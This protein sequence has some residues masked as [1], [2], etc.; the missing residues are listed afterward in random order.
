MLVTICWLLL[1]AVAAVN[2]TPITSLRPIYY[3]MLFTL[4]MPAGV[5]M[6]H[7]MMLRDDAARACH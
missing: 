4:M 7:I 2:I 1:A 3:M 6:P 5:I